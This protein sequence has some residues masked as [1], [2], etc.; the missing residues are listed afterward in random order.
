[1]YTVGLDVDTRA[2]FTAATLI[3]AV[4]TGIKI[5][6]W[7][8]TCYG[9]SI[10]MTPSM[11]FSLGFVFMFT[12]GGLS[13]VVLANASLDIAF[14]DTYYVVAQMGLNNFYY[15]AIDYM[16]EH[17]LSVNYLLFIYY[18]LSIFLDLQAANSFNLNSENNNYTISMRQII[19]SALVNMDINYQSAENYKG[20]SET[21]CQSLNSLLFKRYSTNSSLATNK[22]T[23]SSLATNKETDRSFATDKE[24]NSS[25][26]F[27]NESKFFCWLAGIIDG[28]GNFL[29]KQGQLKAITIRLHNKDIRILTRIQSILHIG[30]I[31]HYDSKYY[32]TYI[33]S[34]EENMRYLIQKL[35]GLIRIKYDS[36]QKACILF[37]IRLIEPSYCIPYNNS[38]FSGLIDT[39]GTLYLNYLSNRIECNLQ[40][41][42]N[43]YTVKLNFDKV[44][45]LCTPNI[46]YSTNF[47]ILNFK[48]QSVNS[49]SSMYEYFM[50]NRLYSDYKFH[51]VSLIKKFLEIRHCQYADKN[52]VN[53][54]IYCDFLFEW[55]HYNNSLWT[56]EPF[57]QEVKKKYDEIVR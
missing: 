14:H 34:D 46:T 9:G 27:H 57:I 7:L 19:I 17:I 54:A 41:K 42:R 26:K 35:N 21:I 8:A 29:I 38:Y 43:K 1:M 20:F 13:G 12:I 30:K 37:D 28:K 55:F 11:L 53:Y 23:D 47:K 3:I 48:Y 6:S 45:L 40:L 51:K 24:K 2:Y 39:K 33:I 50:E 10:K 52:S 16:L 18:Y 32:S 56:R 36:F 22:D 31:I 5:F 15:S 4:P 25:D 49:M 44:M